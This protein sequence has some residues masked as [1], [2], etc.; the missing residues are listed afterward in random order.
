[1]VETIK[2]YKFEKPFVIERNPFNRFCVSVKSMD[3]VNSSTLQEQHQHTAAGS[4]SKEEGV[5]APTNNRLHAK[6]KSSSHRKVQRD[7]RKQVQSGLRRHTH[8]ER[9]D[10]ADHAPAGHHSRASR[11]AEKSLGSR[12]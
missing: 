10:A 8:A 1:M 12:V 5:S 4:Y 11:V 7:S 6:R 9:N 3:I 2:Q